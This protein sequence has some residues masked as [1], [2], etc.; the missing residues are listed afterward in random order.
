[1]RGFVNIVIVGAQKTGTS[2][3]FSMLEQQ[4]MVATAFQKEIHFFNNVV[5]PEFDFQRYQ[6]HVLKKQ[7]KRMLMSPDY[8]RYVR[9]YLHPNSAFTDDWYRAIFT[10]KPSNRIRLENGERPIFLEASPNYFTLPEAGVARMRHVLGDIEPIL[11]V[12]DP[13]RRMISGTSMMMAKRPD[14]FANDNDVRSFISSQ[15][16]PKGAYSKAIPLYRKYFSRFN[17][18][19]FKMI[20]DAPHDLLRTIETKYG[21]E[22]IEYESV[23]KKLA[24][25]SGQADLSDEVKAFMRVELR[26]RV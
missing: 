19:P 20:S 7:Q 15:Q 23:E 3:L 26:S 2:W 9:R 12:R 10:E 13:L 25:A 5:N 14:R 16:V 1:M 11:L 21:L 22:S 4:P 6:R 18:I 17:I 8:R 24:S